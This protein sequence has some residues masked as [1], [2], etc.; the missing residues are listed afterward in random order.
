MKNIRIKEDL[1]HKNAKDAPEF[2]RE[3][4]GWGFSANPT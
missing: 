4:R 3:W 2:I 1:K